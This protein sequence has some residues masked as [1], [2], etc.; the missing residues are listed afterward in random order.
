MKCARTKKMVYLQNFQNANFNKKA[1]DST[2]N[3]IEIFIHLC[4]IM[5][6]IKLISSPLA[7]FSVSQNNSKTLCECTNSNIKWIY[8]VRISNINQV[9]LNII[10][11]AD[12]LGCNCYIQY[13]SLW[14][15]CVGVQFHF[16]LF[17]K[18]NL[19][20]ALVLCV[21]LGLNC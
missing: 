13:I 9:I 10:I 16:I 18:V 3:L 8:N 14:Y 6:I 7:C 12:V 2:L 19:W 4:I 15:F 1:L 21:S 17:F 11:R 5:L 20:M